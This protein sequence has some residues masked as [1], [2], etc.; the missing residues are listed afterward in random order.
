MRLLVLSLTAGFLG[1]L[2]STKLLVEHQVFAQSQPLK[3][4]EVEE[5][6]IVDGAG[7]PRG[8]FDTRN[9]GITLAMANKFG[10]NI[11]VLDVTEDDD[12]PSLALGDNAGQVRFALSVIEQAAALTF[13]DR[14]G[15]E[16]LTL[17]VTE[18]DAA[19]L[20]INDKASTGGLTLLAQAVGDSELQIIDLKGSMRIRL[21]TSSDGSTAI[22]LLDSEG[23]PRTLIAV[24]EDDDAGIVIVDE[25]GDVVQ[26]LGKDTP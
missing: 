1:G 6:R 9:G 25:K 4:L 7:S 15:R 21:A 2:L 14:D 8:I 19:A 3:L 18:K 22:T 13:S 20:T 5:L 12:V 23:R 24:T 26:F 17:G 11:I 16:R 10:K